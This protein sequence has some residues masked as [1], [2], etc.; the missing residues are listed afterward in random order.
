MNVLITVTRR[1]PQTDPTGKIIGERLIENTVILPESIPL[2]DIYDFLS[3]L[4]VNKCSLTFETE[5]RK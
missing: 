1:L 3:Q 2:G 4:N 5:G